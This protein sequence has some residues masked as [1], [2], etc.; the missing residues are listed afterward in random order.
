MLTLLACTVSVMTTIFDGLSVVSNAYTSLSI[1]TKYGWL[2]SEIPKMVLSPFLTVSDRQ[3]LIFSPFHEIRVFILGPKYT[4]NILNDDDFRN[5]FIR[6]YSQ[7]VSLELFHLSTRDSLIY[8]IVKD[9]KQ[10]N[11]NIEQFATVYRKPR[12]ARSN[13]IIKIY[14]KLDSVYSQE[15]L[16]FGYLSVDLMEITNYI[17]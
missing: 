7:D 15:F 5:A 9:I 3:K 2:P 10:I 16:E 8:F 14:L 1:P 13:E 4:Y 17:E 11:R 6:E 12:N